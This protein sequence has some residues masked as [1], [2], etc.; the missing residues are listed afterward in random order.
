MSN[1]LNNKKWNSTRYLTIIA[2]LIGIR[3]ILGYLPSIKTPVV[4]LGWGFIGTAFTGALFNPLISAFI[5]GAA[6]ILT[7]FINGQGNFFFGYT[8][9]AVL[10]GVIYSIGLYKK[11]KT[12]LRIGA[13]VLIV[14]LFI[15]IFLGSL[16]IYMMRYE[17]SVN[18]IGN[19]V[20]KL[21]YHITQEEQFWV[22]MTPRIVK[23]LVSFPL[24]TLALMLL[25]KQPQILALIK[26]YE[27]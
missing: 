1:N 19:F 8:L 24:N 2:L 11:P 9:S 3:I 21:W 13:I 4:Q 17:P 22:W 6:D 10:A 20:A 26:K 15:N 5:G 14:T 16:W 12:I 25:F 18:F 27:L 7:F 23:N